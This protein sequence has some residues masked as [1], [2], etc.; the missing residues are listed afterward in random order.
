MKTEKQ[1]ENAIIKAFSKECDGVAIT[2]REFIKDNISSPLDKFFDKV[3][4]KYRTDLKV[5]IWTI[6]HQHNVHIWQSITQTSILET[7]LLII[8]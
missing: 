2:R 7:R 3:S 8:C 5:K 4:G 6:L 1:I